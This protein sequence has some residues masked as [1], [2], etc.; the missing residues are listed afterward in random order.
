M[1]LL[2]FP[3][4]FFFASIYSE[5]L[6]LL[7][8]L[9]AFY[10][11]RKKMW[12]LAAV[13]AILLTSTRL[14]GIAILPALLYEFYLQEMRVGKRVI[15][16]VKS[17]LFFVIP[18][19]LI[20]YMAYNYFTWGNALYFITAQGKFDNN[21]SVTSVVLLPQTMYRYIKILLDFFP[22]QFEWW[23][24]LFEFLIFIFVSILLFYAWRKKVRFSYLL[25]SVICLVIPASTGTLTGLPRYALVLF[26]VFIA[27]SLI[28]NKV[29]II[30]YTATSILLSILLLLYFSR[31]YF[32][33]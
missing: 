15:T 10:F 12:L 27:L 8:S 18:T 28:K 1:F 25:F 29:V 19:G 23:I 5:S 2:V 17:L 6:F 3:T 20:S 9:L 31:G 33:G 32:V 13:A 7:L 24:A 11:A 14:V 22:S 30:S 4:S 16:I 21:R 26:P